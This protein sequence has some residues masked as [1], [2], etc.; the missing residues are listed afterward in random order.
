MRGSTNMIPNV[1]WQGDYPFDG[2]DELQTLIDTENSIFSRIS[3]SNEKQKLDGWHSLRY[4]KL[5][6]DCGLTDIHLYPFAHAI[7]YNDTDFDLDYRK[8]LLIDE[9]LDDMQWK[10]SRYEQNKTFYLEH[11]FTEQKLSKMMELLDTKVQYIKNNFEDDTSFEWQGGFN[12]IVTGI[13]PENW[14]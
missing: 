11:G 12:F 7:C 1:T 4:P 6:S 9:T 13:K 2:A 8:T 5:L 14:S 3:N 10:K